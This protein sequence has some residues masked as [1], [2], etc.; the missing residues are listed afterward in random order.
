MKITIFAF[1]MGVTRLFT[2]GPGISLYNFAK[3]IGKRFE[4]DIFTTLKVER[5]IDGF[6]YYSIGDIP[7]LKRSIKESNYVHHW[8]GVANHYSV[9]GKIANT[10]GVPVIIGPNVLDCVEIGKERSLLGAVEA[11]HVL[12]V[13]DR[14]KYK[15]SKEHNLDLRKM[16]TFI[17]GPEMGLWKPS[18]KD[19]GFIMWK[20]NSKHLA[21]D[22][23]FGLKLEGALPQYDFK[24]IGHPSPY[25]YSDH[26]DL[27]KSARLYVGTS[28]SET[29]SQT[30]MESWAS[31]V[32][33]VT[34]PKIYLHGKNY[35]TGIITNKTIEDYSEAIIEIMEDE[36]L[37][38]NLKAGA[39]G[40][41]VENFSSEALFSGYCKILGS[42]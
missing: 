26:I 7:R 24:F 10:Y 19:A 17:V 34:H 9:A 14:L 42:L 13:N 18:G 33:S 3:S 4:V 22:I 2:N 40:Y 25:S 11:A 30:L 37:R 20:G 38:E 6:N 32:C 16:S 28:I 5:K 31:G 21:K 41:A 29:K 8:S 39:Y 27:A 12:S 36:R 35:E 1:N 15:I 23:G